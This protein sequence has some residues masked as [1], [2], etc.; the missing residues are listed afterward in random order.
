VGG[1]VRR[2]PHRLVRARS[3]TST[4]PV[5]GSRRS[6][7]SRSEPRPP[8]KPPTRPKTHYRPRDKTGPRNLVDFF[9]RQLNRLGEETGYLIR[10]SVFLLV[11]TTAITALAVGSLVAAHIAGVPLW[12][13]F[14]LGAGATAI[15]AG[16][17]TYVNRRRNRSLPQPDTDPTPE[18]EEPRA[19]DQQ[20]GS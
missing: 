20:P 9:D 4:R 17:G 14:S 6:A 2:P 5:A 18:P 1:Q 13:V 8:P 11:L 15:G 3:S 10:V 12:A 19:P 7:S 16:A